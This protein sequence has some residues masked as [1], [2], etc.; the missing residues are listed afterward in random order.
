MALFVR[1]TNWSNY[2]SYEK[3]TE[4][5]RNKLTVF[6]NTEVKY[7][8]DGK[9]EYLEFDKA[10]T[11]MAMTLLLEFLE[12]GVIPDLS[13]HYYFAAYPDLITF[14]QE[15]ITQEEKDVLGFAGFTT[16]ILEKMFLSLTFP[17][18]TNIPETK[19]VL[20]KY[21]FPIPAEYV[22]LME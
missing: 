19:A 11:S 10:I 18:D 13:D 14:I 22:S 5:T 20:K 8:E 1:T 6:R 16:K 3:I 7:T 21:N 17:E 4:E 2:E 15:Q 9:Y 12:N